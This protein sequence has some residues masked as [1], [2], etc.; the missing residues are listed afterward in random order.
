MFSSVAQNA[1]QR[2][3]GGWDFKTIGGVCVAKTKNKN[4][5]NDSS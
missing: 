4:Q 3:T 5:D 1:E 2:K